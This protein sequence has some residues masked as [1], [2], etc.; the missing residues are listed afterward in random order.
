[1]D[2]FQGAFKTETSQI[3]NKMKRMQTVAKRRD[4]KNHI[5]LK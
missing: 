1:M 2:D 3:K 5:K 4:I